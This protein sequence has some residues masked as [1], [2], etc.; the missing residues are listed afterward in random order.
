MRLVEIRD[1]D[2]PNLFMLRPTIKIELAAAADLTADAVAALEA[3]LEPLGIS[4]EG[5]AGGVAELG[6]VLAEAVSALHRRLG[7]G[8]PET[9]AMALEEPE[10]LAVAF[11][12]TRRAFAL[13]LA[14]VVAAWAVGEAVDLAAAEARLRL[15]LASP[16]DADDVPTWVEDAA[17]RM[18]IVGV[19]GTNGKT[20]TTRMIAHVLR[21]AGQRVGWSSSSGVYVDGEPVI[22][23]D[24]SGPVGARR[25][26][27]EPGLDTAVLETARGGIL[28]RGLG[29]A[30]N[31]VSV[32]LN[33]SSDHLGLQGVHTLDGL[34]RVKAVVAQVTG[35]AGYAVLN[36][37]DAHVRGVAGGLRASV[38]WVT[39]HA[40]HPTV[41]AHVGTG[42]RALFVRD[43][44]VVE[45]LG[46]Q[47]LPL[48]D[49][50][51]IPITFGGRARHMIENALCAAAACLALGIPAE[52]IRDGLM[53]FRPSAEDNSG[54]LNVYDVGGVTVI[55][56][57]AHNEA[58]LAHLLEF[59]RTFGGEG[60]RLIAIIGTAGD[61]TDDALR[62][63]GQLAASEADH[64]IVKETT[65]YLRGRGS[66]AEMTQRFEDGIAEGGGT[67]YEIAAGELAG[68]EAGLAGA[69][70][71]D[72]IAMMCIEEGPEVQ[73]R[74]QERGRSLG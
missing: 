56:D 72:V 45:A 22:A 2:G 3:R 7:V 9:T 18:A 71:G 10:H 43:G 58:G 25:V 37:D 74:L 6:G 38:F 15:L 50:A 8:L 30:S 33:V 27:A 12:W 67:P 39:Q 64:V 63:L 23:G 32:F 11:S 42:G 4:D 61:R 54:R 49:V 16:A 29:Y 51:D 55:V 68:F 73:R 60:T 57:Y 52:R 47:E 40:N 69:I 28:L 17:R 59:A 36:A 5:W 20:T 53:S 48:L 35:P 44:S 65:R 24:Y 46:A 21:R 26:L 31:D 62:A 41:M 1:L 34:A 13:E 14:G 70:A 19:T 66:P